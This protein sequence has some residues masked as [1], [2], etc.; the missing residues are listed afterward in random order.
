M[1]SAVSVG[2]RIISPPSPQKA[3]QEIVLDKLAKP[4]GLRDWKNVKKRASY[5]PYHFDH[6]DIERAVALALAE[7]R[8]EFEKILGDIEEGFEGTA[9]EFCEK[10]GNASYTGFKECLKEIKKRLRGGKAGK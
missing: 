5:D 3:L 1:E 9:V 4:L 2:K 6:K 7:Q 8:K 10:H